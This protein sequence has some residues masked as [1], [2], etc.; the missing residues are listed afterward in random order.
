MVEEPAVRALWRTLNFREMKWSMKL[1]PP[2]RRSSS[3][4]GRKGIEA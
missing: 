1:S 4:G 3:G 2:A